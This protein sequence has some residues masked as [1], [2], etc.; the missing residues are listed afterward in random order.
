MKLR[1][2]LNK[3]CKVHAQKTSLYTFPILK[4]KQNRHVTARKENSRQPQKFLR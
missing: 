2:K 3:P 4:D 1:V